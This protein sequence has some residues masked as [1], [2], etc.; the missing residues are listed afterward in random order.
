[1]LDGGRLAAKT[2]K[3]AGVEVVFAIHG[4]HLDTIL[5]GCKAEGIRLVDF[6]HEAAAVNAADG[7]ARVTGKIGVALVTS[8]P[9]LTNGLAGITNAAGDR[10]P[11]LIITSSP[12][13][14]ELETGELQGG[15]DFIS[16]LNPV[17]K[18]AHKVLS[19]ERVPDIVGLGIRHAL[20]APHGPAV[21]DLPIDI[22]F[23]PVDENALPNPGSPTVDASPVP[24]T[25][26]IEAAVDAIA[27]AERP[28]LVTG[29][30]MLSNS[31]SAPALRTFAEAT[32]IPVFNATLAFSCLPGA[33][34]QN[35]GTLSFLPLVDEKPDLVILAGARQGMFIGGRSGGL[36]PPAAKIV[37]MDAD[38]A[39]IGRLF[40]VDVPLVGECAETL[41]ALARAKNW[42]SPSD[43]CSKAT[44]IRGAGEFMFPDAAM[45]E[46]G[47]HPYRVAKNVMEVL[48]P[49][50]ILVN[51]GGECAAWAS[52]AIGATELFGTL[53]LGYQGHLGVGQ[54]FAIGAQIAHPDKRVVQITGDG[55][56]GMH[57]QEWDTMVRHE[58]PIVTII[59]NNACWGM[60][61]HG[62]QAVFGED[63]DVITRL[64]R[65][66]YDQVAEGFEAHGEFVE[67]LDELAPALQRALAC[68][69]AAVVNVKVSGSV[70]HPVTNSLL[71]DLTAENEIIVPYYQNIP[72]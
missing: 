56:I 22:A 38:A 50:T 33:H 35:G 10:V 40:P 32:G 27:R 65:S 62:Q 6:R 37:Q 63:G 70:V 31:A 5:V 57:L 47:I 69:K 30:G 11:V 17:T 34:R 9:G 46:D 51:D 16:M 68:G 18:F 13:I 45:E 24:S 14:R 48:P 49:E 25:T 39:E 72:K 3:A 19:A 1:M 2:L 53:N 20:T 64:S 44:S 36:I 43:W 7:Y 67:T 12:P 71:G 52:F 58:L 41:E 21:V 4:G 23:T 29:E 61:I 60:S 28:V 15:L 55:A 54:G 26:S 59:F 66:R 8:G 42:Q